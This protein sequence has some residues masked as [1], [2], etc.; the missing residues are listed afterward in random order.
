VP[1]ERTRTFPTLAQDVPSRP[2]LGYWSSTDFASLV[3]LPR[4]A[5]T[6]ITA[7]VR[8]TATGCDQAEVPAVSDDLTV[9]RN[10]FPA[11]SI[12]RE[13]TPGRSRYVARSRHQGLNPHTV[14][15]DD[16]QE[17]RDALQ[18]EQDPEATNRGPFS[19]QQPDVASG[20]PTLG[21]QPGPFAGTGSSR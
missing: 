16:L 15:T 10:E 17:L 6:P 12:W 19:P 7:G 13:Q 20:L 11:F 21:A 9:L 18:P 3:L 5:T 14:V 4:T 8:G 2:S 1:P